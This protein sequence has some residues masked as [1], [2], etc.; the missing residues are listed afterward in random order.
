[1]WNYYYLILCIILNEIS[2][3]SS[4]V[5]LRPIKC[6]K[7]DWTLVKLEETQ[8]I[9]SKWYWIIT[10]SSHLSCMYHMSH[11]IGPH[12]NGGLKNNLLGSC[13]SKWMI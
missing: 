12:K 7:R 5:W 8:V 1:L 11:D 4:Y 6:Q 3:F 9:L 10:S 13:I 2:F